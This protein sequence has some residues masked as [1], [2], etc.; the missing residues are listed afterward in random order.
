[1]PVYQLQLISHP[2]LAS[3]F[4]LDAISTFYISTS[5]PQPPQTI[6]ELW[7]E[8]ETQFDSIL[9]AR[10]ITQ[11]IKILN[12]SGNSTFTIP[13]EHIDD[14]ENILNNVFVDDA[15]VRKWLNSHTK[16][17]VTLFNTGLRSINSV[18]YIKLNEI[19]IEEPLDK[20]SSK[21]PNKKPY[22]RKTNTDRPKRPTSAYQ[23]YIS[24]NQGNRTLKT[25]ANEWSTLSS[26][27]RAKW[28]ELALKDKQRYNSEMTEWKKDKI[29]RG[30]PPNALWKQDQYRKIRQNHPDWPTKKILD[31]VKIK[32]CW[33]E[34]PF[35]DQLEWIEK[36]KNMGWDRHY[37]RRRNEKFGRM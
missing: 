8:N 26:T 21:T 3:N 29:I 22:I 17:I 4:G 11:L 14:F 30:T 16:H 19:P 10:Q 36:A 2:E 35:E 12:N 1:M 23:Y 6:L 24:E 18:S 27:Q 7:L 28:E 25:V 37:F 33:D 13:Y 15:D 34:L 20:N 9:F 31:E 32:N 5:K